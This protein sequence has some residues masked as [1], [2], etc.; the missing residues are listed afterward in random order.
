MLPEII[1][2]AHVIKWLIGIA[3]SLGTIIITMFGFYINYRVKSDSKFKEKM[4]TGLNDMGKSMG[5]A[6]QAHARIESNVNHI[7]DDVSEMKGKQEEI[8]R[9]VNNAFKKIGE[10]KTDIEVL[11]SKKK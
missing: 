11:K 10:N 3:G 1:T 7:I 9:K 8:H 2:D 4:E 5:L 6:Q